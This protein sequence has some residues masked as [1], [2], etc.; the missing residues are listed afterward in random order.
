VQNVSVESGREARMCSTVVSTARLRAANTCGGLGLTAR[1]PTRR[2]RRGA[3]HDE[4]RHALQL[5]GNDPQG[6]QQ[7]IPK[8]Q[9]GLAGG[10][11]A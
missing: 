10:R 7:R 3:V 9:D 6:R 8:G 4:E 11:T 5:S 2:R 1:R